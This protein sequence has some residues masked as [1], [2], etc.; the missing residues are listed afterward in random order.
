MLA[1]CA[2]KFLQTSTSASANGSEIS[3]DRSTS[4]PERAGGGGD[5]QIIILPDTVG[6]SRGEAEAALRKAGVQGSINIQGGGNDTICLQSP[7]GGKETRTTLGVTL[8]PCADAAV[9]P[10]SRQEVVLVGLT[11]EE[12][13]KRIRAAG[14]TGEIKVTHTANT[15]ASCKVG[16]VCAVY[17][18]H[19]RQASNYVQLDLGKG[20]DEIT[21]PD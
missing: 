1:G 7:G 11:V 8:T 16:H 19:W 9:A 18:H 6:M 15:N 14:F 20:L 17:P 3:A 12:A 21:V 5:A 2:G 10:P 4:A 13:T